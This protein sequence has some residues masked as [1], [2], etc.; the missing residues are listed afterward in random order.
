MSGP[1]SFFPCLPPSPVPPKLKTNADESL[2]LYF[3]LDVCPTSSL[4]KNKYPTRHSMAELVSK[5]TDGNGVGGKKDG[6]GQGAKRDPFLYNPRTSRIGIS[7]G[8][9]VSLV[10]TAKV[11]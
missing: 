4:P 9:K 10:L 7:V 2:C 1:S 6:K 11:R 3:G 5:A 8:D